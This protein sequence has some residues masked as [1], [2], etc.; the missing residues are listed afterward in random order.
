MRRRRS[1]GVLRC[2]LFAVQSWSLFKF[3]VADMARPGGQD[4]QTILHQPGSIQSDSPIPDGGPIRKLS[5]EV[6]AGHRRRL[7]YLRL[8]A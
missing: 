1:D 5:I 7:A 3:R 4:Y 8:V 6:K 2:D